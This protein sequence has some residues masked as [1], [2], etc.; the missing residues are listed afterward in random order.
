VTDGYT[1]LCR[2]A[3]IQLGLVGPLLQVGRTLGTEVIRP[4]RSCFLNS[5]SDVFVRSP[6]VQRQ[7]VNRL[8]EQFAQP[9]LAEPVR[10]RAMEDDDD[11]R[12][13]LR[14]RQA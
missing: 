6:Q 1:L 2:Y 4:L 13:E 5:V 8:R 10:N 9:A 11:D 14:R 7:A 3:I 12:Q